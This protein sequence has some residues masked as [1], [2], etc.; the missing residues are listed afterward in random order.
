[1]IKIFSVFAFVV[2]FSFSVFGQQNTWVGKYIYS[3]AASANNGVFAWDY[4]LTVSQKGNDLTGVFVGQGT[5]M[6]NNFEVKLVSENSTIKVL[7]QKDLTGNVKNWAKPLKKGQLLFSLTK[8]KLKGK[9]RY[10][11]GRNFLLLEGAKRM[12]FIRK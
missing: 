9:E 1:M 12:Y 6:D 11:L 7:F 4:V 3:Y 5:Q 2:V 8:V 10:L